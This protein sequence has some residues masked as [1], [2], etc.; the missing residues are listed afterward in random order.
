MRA[1]SRSVGSLLSVAALL[2][3]F[4]VP[5]YPGELMLSGT[6]VTSAVSPP[7]SPAV[8]LF[9]ELGAEYLTNVALEDILQND[10]ELAKAMVS[11]GDKVIAAYPCDPLGYK[12][13]ANALV[14]ACKTYEAIGLVDKVAALTPGRQDGAEL[15]FVVLAGSGRREE[16]LALAYKVIQA[17][18]DAEK[19]YRLAISELRYMKRPEEALAVLDKL[20]QNVPE[21]KGAYYEKFSLLQE[22]KRYPE[23][24]AV[25]EK[26]VE[27]GQQMFN[28][29]APRV[30]MLKEIHRYEEALG[31]P[32]QAVEAMAFSASARACLNNEKLRL[33]VKTKRCEDAVASVDGLVALMP[34]KP[35]E[36]RRR[37]RVQ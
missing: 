27:R 35:V 17:D 16:A 26:A 22:M 21:A 1:L 37:I 7:D 8:Q 2:F 4:A 13:K 9:A 34:E 29:K 31:V 10:D 3:A 36:L 28:R 18:P 19:M 33:L 14:R 6:G 5:A 23:A 32:D 25:L 24:Q 20:L 15:K 12:I 11:I 30:S